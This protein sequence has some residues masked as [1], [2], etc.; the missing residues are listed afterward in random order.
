MAERTVDLRSD[1]TTRPT[2]EMREAMRTAE[3]GDDGFGDDPTVNRL[4]DL[5]AEKLDME[6]ALLLP[7]GSMANGF[8]LPPPMCPH[9]ELGCGFDERSWRRFGR[10]WFIA[11]RTV[12]SDLIMFPPPDLSQHLS[13]S[14][15]VKISPL[16]SSSRSLPLKLSM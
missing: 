16:R 6:A 9:P 7:T 4:Q 1:T 5:A 12:W 8:D 14:N 13:S 15:V 2:D 3:V 11:E 10:R